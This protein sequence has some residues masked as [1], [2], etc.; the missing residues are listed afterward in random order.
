MYSILK[1][2]NIFITGNTGFVGSNMT[3]FLLKLGARVIGYS[4][5][6]IKR[7]VEK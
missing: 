5:K 4:D 2:K 7:K 3:L 1:N 6:T